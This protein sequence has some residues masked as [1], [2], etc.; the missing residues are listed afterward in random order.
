MKS[1]ARS[2]WEALRSRAESLGATALVA[3]FISTLVSAGVA[4]IFN[5][6]M[7]NSKIHATVLMSE[8][9]QFDASHSNLFGQLAIYTDKL[10]SQDTSATKDDLEKAIVSAQLQLD[11]L[12]SDLPKH[13]QGVVTEYSDE[14]EKFMLALR[15]VNGR[16]NLK[17]VYVSA[18]KLLELNDKLADTVRTNLAVNP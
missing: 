8:K 2:K 1:T 15:A 6:R 4:S 11:R 12:K 13:N 9:A 17:P 5:A 3:T 16:A 10:L 7:E 18:Q 14:L